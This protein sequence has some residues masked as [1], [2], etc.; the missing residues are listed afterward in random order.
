MSGTSTNALPWQLGTAASQWVSRSMMAEMVY[1]CIN[2][3]SF[4]GKGR[5]LHE[6]RAAKL[7]S[8]GKL[9]GK[10]ATLQA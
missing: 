10:K 9:Q 5:V 2:R 4:V 6:N 7:E 8:P 1:G 3:T